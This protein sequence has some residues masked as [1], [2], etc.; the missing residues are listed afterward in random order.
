MKFRQATA[1]NVAEQR[2]KM[3]PKVV[4]EQDK[5]EG[6]VTPEE[7]KKDISTAKTRDE[8][9]MIKAKT[10]KDAE[11][12]ISV[13]LRLEP[14]MYGEIICTLFPGVRVKVNDVPD[15]DEWYSLTY[16]GRDC[17]VKKEFIKLI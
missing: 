17:F 1:A 8:V 16:Q 9:K 13:N 15:N 2:A 14:G 10:A 3:D 11:A 7:P 4:A 5:K 12:I 6:I